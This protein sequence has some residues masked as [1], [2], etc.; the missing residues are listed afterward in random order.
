M[1]NQQRQ[2]VKK[3]IDLLAQRWR[4]IT[5][6]ILAALTIGLGIYLRMPKLYHCTALLSYEKQQINPGRMAPEREGQ[7]LRETVSTLSELVMS[8]NNL[9][10]F[11]KQ[12]DLYP[13]ARKKLPIEDVIELMRKNIKVTPSS[14]GDTFSV[15][16]Q[17]TQQDKVLKVTNA[18]AAKFI[19]EN[20]KYR[21]ERAT[22]TSKYTKDELTMAKAVLD[23]KE[24]AMRDFKLKHYNEM[25]E[26]RADNLARLT[27]LHEQYQGIQDS[28]QDLE[29]TRVMAQE[30]ISLRKRLG[31]ALAG[32]SSSGS[33]N[34]PADQPMGKYERLQR[35][36]QYLAS[37]LGKY[38]DK[39]PEVR[40]TRQLIAKLEADLRNNPD[41]GTATKNSVSR[42][43]LDP[44]I[45]QLKFQIKGIDLN[46]KKLKKD[47][48]KV[49][50]S[51]KQHEK[52]IEKT[53]VREAQWNALTRD[54][55]ELRR[56]YDYLVSQ[57]LQAASVEHLERKQ[58]GSKFKIIDPARFPDKPFKPDFKKMLLLALGAGGGLG[59]GLTLVLDFVDTSFKDVGEIESQLGIK[60]ISAVPYI[61]LAEE[62][63]KKRFRMLLSG[64]LF[65][66]Y[67]LL[68]IGIMIFL[69]LHGKIIV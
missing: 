2:Q 65:F 53:P 68:L 62:T 49:L 42:V 1:E 32:N 64:I 8:R 24:Q 11:I 59:I 55:N 23:K 56:N 61:E 18:L 17:G 22:E 13:K 40:R 7:R 60:V 30:Q 52:W 41:S 9:E 54:Y 63:R 10:E 29:R 33:G 36:K 25:P 16:F 12:F 57:N 34:R 28:I 58:K 31:N 46:I 21:E 38:T 6:C 4:L 35:L 45:Q 69:Y 67:T 37:L 27:A 26:Q 14:R 66:L 51:I 47:Q 5:A 19:E 15:T 39:H 43:P 44:E 50:A 3:Y 48:K 20:L